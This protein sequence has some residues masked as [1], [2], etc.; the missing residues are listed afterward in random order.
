MSAL[1]KARIAVMVVRVVQVKGNRRVPIA[2]AQ[3]LQALRLKHARLV[4]DKVRPMPATRL[5][6]IVVAQLR[7]SVATSRPDNVPVRRIV[8]T[9]HANPVSRVPL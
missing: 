9:S 3:R 2:K 5:Q 1:I 8:L 4:L 6:P 7:T